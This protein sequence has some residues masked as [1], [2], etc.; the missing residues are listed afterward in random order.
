ME[1]TEKPQIQEITND[2]NYD[3]SCKLTSLLVSDLEYFQPLIFV[4]PSIHKT[5]IFH[6]H[7]TY[8]LIYIPHIQKLV[9]M[10][11]GCKI[12]YKNTKIQINTIRNIIKISHK[13]YKCYAKS[14]YIQHI[15]YII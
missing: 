10:T 5:K 12:S 3:T 8:I 14:I 7:N 11:I 4:A 15:S 13:V 2:W 9:R 1:G 6:F